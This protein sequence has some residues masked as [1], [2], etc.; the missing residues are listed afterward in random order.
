MR[1]VLSVI[2]PV[3]REG[4]VIN[5][6]ISHLKTLE[7]ELPTEVIVADG[8]PAGDT[9]SAIAGE[10]VKKIR[11]AP[12]RGAQMNAGAAEASGEILLFLHADTKLPAGAGRRIAALCDDPAIA[13]GAFDLLIDSPR[14]VFRVI[15]KA[16]SLR[17]RATRIPYGDQAVFIKAGVFHSIGGFRPLAIME[18]IDL[19][20]RLKR[21]GNR[22]R[23]A[24]AAVRTSPRRWEK[25]GVLYT[26][27]RNWLLSTFFYLGASPDRLKR[28][29]R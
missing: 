9:L 19:M 7:E 15:E 6:V 13:G 18:D 26:T 20:Q 5:D 3:L 1:P 22:I 12:G 23:F 14:P 24:D 27:L 10:G 21:R 2:I 16:A 11:C 25:E 17:S 29:Y 8:A 28:Y 4:A